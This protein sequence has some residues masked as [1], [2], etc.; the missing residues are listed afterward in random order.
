[1]R[2]EI[3]RERLQFDEDQTRARERQAAR[4]SELR[5]WSDRVEGRADDIHRVK[6]EFESREAV[7][8][9]RERAVELAER[10][11]DAAWES[12]RAVME[13]EISSLSSRRKLELDARQEALALR[14]ASVAQAEAEFAAKHLT[15]EQELATVRAGRLAV[16]D[17]DMLEE[18]REREAVIKEDLDRIRR[19]VIETEHRRLEEERGQ[20]GAERDRLRKEE[21]RLQALADRLAASEL[22][23]SSESMLAQSTMAEAQELL[24]KRDDEIALRVASREA[25]LS[26]KERVLD[27]RMDDV[28]GWIEDVRSREIE[29][30]REAVERETRVSDSLRSQLELAESATRA[31]AEL[32]RKF[33]RTPEEVLLEV[34][35]LRSERNRLQTALAARVASETPEKKR[36][37]EENARLLDSFNRLNDRISLSEREVLSSV[38]A[39]A[40]LRRAEQEL[41]T[42]QDD[43][44]LAGLREDKLRAELDRLLAGS[45]RAAVRED[46]ISEIRIP[47]PANLERR[48]DNDIQEIDWLRGLESSFQD[49]GFRFHPRILRAFH[50]SL[51]IAEWSPLTILAGVSGT[52]KSELPKLYCRHGGIYFHS[53]PVMPN[54]DS[55]ESMLGYF[56]SIDNRFDAQPVLRLLD[57]SQRNPDDGFGLN[58]AMVLVLLDELN[59]AHPELYFAE[60][61][62]KLETRRGARSNDLPSLEVK[63]GSG[64]EPYRIPLGRNVRW[65]G[66][67][68]QDETTKSLSDKV[69]DR[70][71]VVPFPRPKRLESRPDLKPESHAVPLIKRKVWQGWT[72]HESKHGSF[73][74]QYAAEMT[75]V[76]GAIE[77]INGALSTAGRAIGHRVWQSIEYYLANYPETIA[78]TNETDLKEAMRN[79][80]EDQVVQKIIPKVRG[81]DTSG[82][83]KRDCLDPIQTTLA[84]LG[85]DDVVE[86]FKRSC[87]TGYGQ[88]MWQS[89]AFLSGFES[90]SGADET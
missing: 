69:L 73:G 77:T 85:Y 6:L 67:M 54:W 89:E 79:A 52:G 34:E 4:E 68:N 61:L 7:L 88:F 9:D 59:L 56:N 37:Q 62:S 25:A 63:L 46:R 22:R 60:F 71:I 32:T 47:V 17:A 2:S 14:E 64:M 50:T 49:A 76:K 58:D 75:R 87:E 19:G 18:R 53:L 8:R 40:D 16:L 21:E 1:M 84:N 82:S 66:T 11:R 15:L 44:E 13:A 42:L 78:A 24:K 65:V 5:A 31:H 74:P 80:L 55:Q 81:V 10:N 36:L 72:K 27:E 35:E 39:K 70:S 86:D 48:G 83:G 41:V 30:L 45:A 29:V 3:E 12:E 38:Q 57:Q 28:Q 43:L 33:A 51:K 20:V 26:L 23:V 90:G